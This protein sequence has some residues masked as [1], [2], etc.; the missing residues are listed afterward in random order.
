[1]ATISRN[2]YGF[3]F[4]RPY[5]YSNS[6]IEKHIAVYQHDFITFCPICSQEIAIVNFKKLKNEC[7]HLMMYK[8]SFTDWT[9]VFD[10]RECTMFY[11]DEIQEY[12]NTI[13]SK[14]LRNEIVRRLNSLDYKEAISAEWEVVMLKWFSHFGRV[15][16]EK[17][18]KNGKKTRYRLG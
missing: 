13:T 8:H 12:I 10:E 17:A 6:T 4:S 7:I 11:F 15:G 18:N 2:D 1:M 9:L 14:K 16:Y 5:T 3:R